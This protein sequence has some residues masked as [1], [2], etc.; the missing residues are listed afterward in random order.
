MGPVVARLIAFTC[1]PLKLAALK[2][3]LF[4]TLIA[5]LMMGVLPVHA[6]SCMEQIVTVRQQLKQVEPHPKRPPSQAQTIGAQ[7]DQQPTA[8]SLAAAG[9]TQPDSGA[10]GALNE[11]MNLDAAGNEAGCLKALAEA[12]RLG[13]LN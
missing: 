2:G 1:L 8:G 12:R 3:V 4:G 6:Q 11:A 7:D 10:Y 5:G 9:V 13:G